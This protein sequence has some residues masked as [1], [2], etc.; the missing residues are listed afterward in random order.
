M[1]TNQRAITNG[2]NENEKLRTFSIKTKTNHAI[3]IA[4]KRSEFDKIENA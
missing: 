2:E 3:I 4:N 1:S